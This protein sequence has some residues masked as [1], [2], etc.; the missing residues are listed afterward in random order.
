MVGYV[1]QCPHLLQRTKITCLNPGRLQ[2]CAESWQAGNGKYIL[3]YIKAVLLQYV[4][5]TISSVRLNIL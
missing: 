5:A 4:N 3:Y 2:G 1:I